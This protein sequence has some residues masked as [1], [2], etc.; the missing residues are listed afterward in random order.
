MCIDGAHLLC[1]YLNI[2]ENKSSEWQLGEWFFRSC[3]IYPNKMWT[4][5]F[6]WVRLSLDLWWCS[7]KQDWPHDSVA[8]LVSILLSNITCVLLSSSEASI[9]FW[10]Y[11][12]T[13]LPFI[14]SCN[15]QEDTKIWPINGI[16]DISES[17]LYLLPCSS[18]GQGTHFSCAGQCWGHCGCSGFT[19]VFL[20]ADIRCSSCSSCV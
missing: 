2:K 20:T 13:M 14:Y 11:K 19:R 15:Q 16:M 7:W 9:K 17:S 18:T 4:N 10:V 1:V 3:L 12:G 6:I 8:A 5:S